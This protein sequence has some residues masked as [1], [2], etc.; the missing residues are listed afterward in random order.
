MP[1]DLTP[2]SLEDFIQ[3]A[4]DQGNVTP[5]RR[6][7]ADAAY[8][9]LKGAAKEYEETVF[10]EQD[11]FLRA[12]G[13]CLICFKDMAYRKLSGNHVRHGERWFQKILREA[14]IKPGTITFDPSPYGLSD[15]SIGKYNLGPIRNYICPTCKSWVMERLEARVN[16]RQER[17]AAEKA[18]RLVDSEKEKIANTAWLSGHADVPLRYWDHQHKLYNYDASAI[19]SLRYSEFLKSRYW[20]IVRSKTLKRHGYRCE[21]CNALGKSDIPLNVHHKTYDHHGQEHL[22][23]E[24]LTVLCKRCHSKFH[25]KLPDDPIDTAV[26]HA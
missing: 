3:L 21:I 23:D 11:S 1:E 6:E 19:A 10:L 20:K 5:F 2:L 4:L 22:Y 18:V 12:H 25:D 8:A 16:E 13:P 15:I 26:A 24:D 9:V 7:D 17:E 14:E